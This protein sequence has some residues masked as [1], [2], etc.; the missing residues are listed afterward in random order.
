MSAFFVDIWKRIC[1]IKEYNGLLVNTTGTPLKLTVSFVPLRSPFDIS[2][3]PGRFLLGS[4]PN[5]A[6]RSSVARTNRKRVKS[7]LVQSSMCRQ[8]MLI[9][10]KCSS[11]KSRISLW[12]KPFPAK[13]SRVCRNSCPPLKFMTVPPAS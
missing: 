7:K 9:I 5:R 10:L 13:I 11:I 8:S 12:I 3:V 2:S 1:S 4:E 6:R